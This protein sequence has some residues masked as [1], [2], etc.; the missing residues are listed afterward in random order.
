M[1]RVVSGGL[2]RWARAG[3]VERCGMMCSWVWLVVRRGLSHLRDA[4]SEAGCKPWDLEE[5]EG[6]REGTDTHHGA[7]R[8]GRDGVGE[9]E[10][11][12]QVDVQPWRTYL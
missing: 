5:L 11:G 12:D 2:E 3:V 8:D 4:R 9:R 7:R 10:G 1:R 6:R